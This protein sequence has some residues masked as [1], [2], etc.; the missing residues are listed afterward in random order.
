MIN[1][2]RRFRFSHALLILAIFAPHSTALVTITD[3]ATDEGRPCFKIE[4]DFATYYLQKQNG[5]FSSL[6]DKDGNDWI[7]FHENICGG[8]GVGARGCFRGIPNLVY[9]D[10]IM[11]PGY[12]TATVTKGKV[13][14]DKATFKVKAK[15]NAIEATYDIYPTHVTLTVTKATKKYWFLYEG[16]PG[17]SLEPKTDFY[18]YPTASSVIRANCSVTRKPLAPLPKAKEWTYFC[19]KGQKRAL[20]LIHVTGDAITDRYY[21]MGGAGGMTVF[22]FGRAG[23]ATCRMSAINNVFSFGLMEDSATAIVQKRISDIQMAQG[24]ALDGPGIAP[25]GT[26]HPEA[27]PSHAIRPV[28]HPDRLTVSLPG[29]GP[30][31]LRIFDATGKSLLALDGIT[32]TP[33]R[34]KMV[35]SSGHVLTGIMGVWLSQDCRQYFAK[36]VH[37]Q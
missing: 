29:S 12:N 36:A 2:L 20:F 21:A 22:G 26:L 5:G 37:L 13:T 7:D 24:G 6:V 32:P 25:T 16:T 18:V 14:A 34:Q 15:S 28:F 35:C 8:G 27:S 9:P 17:G 23:T 1:L 31:H 11:H 19:D 10:N 4:T 30:F 3:N 33:G